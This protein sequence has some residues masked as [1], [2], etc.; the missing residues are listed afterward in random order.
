MEVAAATIIGAGQGVKPSSIPIRRAALPRLESSPR[1]PGV[2]TLCFTA[3]VSLGLFTTGVV[4][5]VLS[6]SNRREAL[7][8]D[9]DGTVRGWNASARGM[10]SQA[11]FN[12]SAEDSLNARTPLVMRRSDSK[13]FDLRD[14]EMGQGVDAY[15]PL[16]YVV[17][18]GFPAD[19]INASFGH[20]ERAWSLLPAR[21]DAETVAFNFSI[22]VSSHG[23]SVLQLGS[24]AVPLVYGEA[25]VPMTEYPDSDCRSA[26][27]GIWRDMRCHV[28]HRL[29]R[30]CVVVE[31]DEVNGWRF[32]RIQRDGTAGSAAGATLQG[33]DPMTKWSPTAYAR[34]FCWGPWPDRR[35]CAA[36]DRRRIQVEVVLRSAEDPF[37][38]AEE[39]T[40]DHFD[41]GAS[42]ESQR[43]SGI[44]FLTVGC[45]LALIPLVRL[46]LH[47]RLCSRDGGDAER[48][49]LSASSAY[50]DRA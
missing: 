8:A 43:T 6:T 44:I 5:L 36:A 26:R 3:C 9:Y 22:S 14:T 50:P 38:R 19:H 32:A 23:S 10:F 29:S 2:C 33:C 4:F 27:R 49:G 15:K 25:R 18:L 13:D 37:L 40:R 48:E 45:V 17:P 20:N 12:V 35:R 34:D 39:L 24:L 47:L 30:L 21:A 28:V 11:H 16:K 7:L 41:F 31:P 42:A 1:G 46:A